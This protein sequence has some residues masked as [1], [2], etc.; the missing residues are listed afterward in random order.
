MSA[1]ANAN[2]S[3]AGGIRA[4]SAPSARPFADALFV[5]LPRCLRGDP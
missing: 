4:G 5:C 1:I 3:G 2:G